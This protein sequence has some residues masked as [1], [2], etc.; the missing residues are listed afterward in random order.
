MPQSGEERMIL[1]ARTVVTMD[2]PPIDNGAVA[3]SGNRIVDVGRFDEI[4]ARNADDVVDLGEQALLPGL[5]NAHCHLDYTS[6]RGKIPKQ[7]SFADWIRAINA[8]KAEISPSGYAAAIAAGFVEAQKFGTTSLVNFEAFPEMI[9]RTSPAIRVWWLPELIDVR[10]PHLPEEIVDLAM[11]STSAVENRGLAPH[12]PFTASLDLYRRCQEI[13]RKYDLILS[14]HLAES[15]EELLMFRDA[16]GPL[17]E[18]LKEIGRDVRGCGRETPFAHLLRHVALDERWLVAHLNELIESDFDLLARS[19][20]K[21]HIVHC[22]RSQEYFGHSPFQ[23]KRLRELGFD[24][25][26]GTDSLASNDDLSLFAEMRAFQENFAEVSPGEIL[27]MVTLNPARALGKAGVLGRI[28]TNYFADMIAVPIG[29]SRK[30]IFDEI[31]GF[32][33]AVPFSI[34]NGVKVGV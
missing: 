14:T 31:V 2:G 25:C 21:F 33:G 26:L 1:R 29:G 6:L 23:F 5:I 19:T 20:T 11:I 13:A 28:R 9:A 24:I 7:E 15:H 4:K 18:F 16:T 12:A 8:A 32:D 22:P 34:I 10:N 27:A 30:D 17:Y 3:I